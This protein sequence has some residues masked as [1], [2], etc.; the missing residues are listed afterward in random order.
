[1]VNVPEEQQQKLL[2]ITKTRIFSR[3][4]L[5]VRKGDIPR[6]FAFVQKGLFR[7]YYV[8]DAG[9][10][11]TKGFFPEFSF[12]AAYSAMVEKRGSF[13][14]IQ[15]LEDAEILVISFEKWK[16]LQKEHICW[17]HFLLALLEKGYITKETRER[18]F[19]LLSAEERY[20][21]FLQRY[22]GLEKRIKQH[23]I[24]SYL[25]ITSV[26]LSRIRNK[27]GLINTG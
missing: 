11:F 3:G 10:E 15:A 16:A 23:V 13:F 8:N 19:L 24:A 14:Y 4:E 12:L 21:A 5:Y 6:S 18:E 22:P 9:N 20:R 17:S 7:Y 26:A 2:S 1:M 27:M 25:G